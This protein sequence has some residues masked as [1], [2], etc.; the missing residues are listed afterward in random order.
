MT[1]DNRLPDDVIERVARAICAADGRKP[2]ESWE[3]WDRDEQICHDA[4]GKRYE[5]P[6]RI[7]WQEYTELA[8]AALLAARDAEAGRLAAD[9][10]RYRWLRDGRICDAVYVVIDDLRRGS[11]SVI[12]SESLDAAID[13]ALQADTAR[14]GEDGRG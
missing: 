8:R 13:A 7:R 10:A 12:H 3:E 1:A 5:P 6:V 9:A 4:V 14:A 2:D 11:P